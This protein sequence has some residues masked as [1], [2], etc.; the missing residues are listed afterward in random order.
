VDSVDYT[1]PMLQQVVRRGAFSDDP[2][3]LV[4]VGCGLGIDPAWRLFEPHLRVEAL[5]PQLDEIERLRSEETNRHVRYHAALVGLPDDDPFLIKR[6]EDES[7]EQA[8]NPWSRLSTAAATNAATRAGD[9]DLEETNDWQLRDLATRKV[10]LAEFLRGQGLSSVD[11]VKTDTDG[12]DFEVLRSFEEAI[13]PLQVLGCVVETPYVGS[14]SETAHTFHNVDRFMKRHGFS[15]FTLSVN[16][17]SRSALPAPFTHSILAQTTWGQAIWGD[18]VYLRDGGGPSLGE[19]SP[20]KLLKLACLCEL[21]RCPDAAAEVL[22]EHRD[23][24][25]PLVDVDRLLDL[26]TPALRG[27]KVTYAEYL[28]AF[29]ADPTSFY[30]ERFNGPPP[31]A[32]KRVLGRA[33]STVGRLRAGLRRSV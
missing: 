14:D 23:A 2:F 6:R 10:G 33:R 25:E 30:P 21:F 13:E 19:M 4:D 11:F 28:A 20:T 26:L 18:L 29:E 16:R 17:Y 22:V 24:L 1:P 31:P 27:R 32:R 15:L 8:Y 12:S 7:S 3:V 5:D 9:T